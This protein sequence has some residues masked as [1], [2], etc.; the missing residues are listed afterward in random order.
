MILKIAD[1]RENGGNVHWCR[2]RGMLGVEFATK[3][4]HRIDSHGSVTSEY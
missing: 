4:R 2:L 1:T 3:I